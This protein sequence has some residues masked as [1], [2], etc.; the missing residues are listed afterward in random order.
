ME[1]LAPKIA[2]LKRK[3]NS[4]L[5]GTE[6]VPELDRRKDECQEKIDELQKK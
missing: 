3:L 2:A 6:S 1:K 4:A 5:G